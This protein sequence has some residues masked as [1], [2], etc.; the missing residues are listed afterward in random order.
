MVMMDKFFIVRGR[1]GF[2]Q[3]WRHVVIHMYATDPS[4]KILGRDL[5]E[6]E[7]LALARIANTDIRHKLGETK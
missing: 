5:S 2:V 6:E 1:S 7:A 4:Y 3:V